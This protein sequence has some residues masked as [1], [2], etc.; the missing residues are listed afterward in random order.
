MQGHYA[1]LDLFMS[2]CCF[3]R[4]SCFRS[5]Q[6][7][8]FS[9]MEKKE[10]LGGGEPRQGLSDWA[11]EG[12]KRLSALCRGA[13][14]FFLDKKEP[15]KSRKNDASPLKANAWLAVLSG[16]RSWGSGKWVGVVAW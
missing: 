15:K 16:L 3:Q 9:S 14:F 12:A 13:R 6:D 1:S 7:C 10:P 8:F 4:Y 11:G 2:Y 5:A